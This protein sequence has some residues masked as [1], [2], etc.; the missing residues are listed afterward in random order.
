MIFNGRALSSVSDNQLCFRRVPH[1]EQV[2]TFALK[3]QCN[4]CRALQ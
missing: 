1:L 4:F 2:F 3:H